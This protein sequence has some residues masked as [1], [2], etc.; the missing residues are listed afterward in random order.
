MNFF[1]AE[2][3]FMIEIISLTLLLY[4][5][6]KNRFYFS[7]KEGKI[8][9]RFDGF[10]IWW[11]PITMGIGALDL[12]NEGVEEAGASWAEF[13]TI[14]ILLSIV[15]SLYVC[16]VQMSLKYVDFVSVMRLAEKHGAALKSIEILKYI[17]KL[18][19]YELE[20]GEYDK[21]FLNFKFENQQDPS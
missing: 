9:K 12:F 6:V 8:K 16:L 20:V 13:V 19:N 1:T 17:D 11:A 7:K 15:I 21:Y 18:N 2:M 10:L 3:R 14:F 5:F 4:L